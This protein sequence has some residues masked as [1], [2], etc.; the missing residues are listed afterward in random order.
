[1]KNLLLTLAVVLV[2]CGISYGVFYAMS[3]DP[4]AVR[5]ALQER[6]AMAWLRSDFNLTDTQFAGIKRLHDDYNAECARHCAAIM[7]ARQRQASPAEIGRLEATCERSMTAH[8][9]QVAALMS[10]EE[11]RRYLAL[12]LPRVAAYD[13]HGAPSVQV[14]P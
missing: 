6:D 14:S 4:A 11:G 9:R 10:P 8:F 1:M 13:H 2:A 12:I 7:A 3:R 5:Q